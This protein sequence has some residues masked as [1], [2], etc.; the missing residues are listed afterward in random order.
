MTGAERVQAAIEKLEGIRGNGEDVWT[1]AG[2]TIEDQHGTRVAQDMLTS[3][4]KAVVT[5][6]RTI[7]A[8]LAVLRV[9][10]EYPFLPLEEPVMSLA[11]AILGSDS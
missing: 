1:A 10:L 3:D 4:A 7:D 6:H 11:A 2:R 8:Q 5:L 9:Y